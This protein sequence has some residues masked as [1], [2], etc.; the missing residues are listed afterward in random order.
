VWGFTDQHSWVPGFFTNPPEGM[1]TLYDE[2]YQPKRAYNTLRADLAFAGPPSV[3]P[4][5]PQQPRR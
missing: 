4:R 1:A 5:V 2:N 3:L